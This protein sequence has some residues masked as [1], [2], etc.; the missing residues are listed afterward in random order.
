MVALATAWRF[1]SSPGHQKNKSTKAKALVDLFLPKRGLG[2]NPMRSP[3][4]NQNGEGEAG[5]EATCR[6]DNVII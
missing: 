2:L 4:C 6:D 1:K 5:V 3:F